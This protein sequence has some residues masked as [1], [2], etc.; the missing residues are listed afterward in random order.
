MSRRHESGKAQEVIHAANRVGLVGC[1]KSKLDEPAPA[2]EL[3]ISP[4]F[5]GR[6]ARVETTCDRWYVL[7]ALHGM[8][9][10]EQVLDPYDRTLVGAPR[11]ERRRWANQVLEQFDA[12]FEDASS[13]MVEVHAGAAYLDHGLVDGLFDR[14]AEVVN[15]VAGLTMGQQLR[16]YRETTGSKVFDARGVLPEPRNS[17]APATGGRYAPLSVHLANSGAHEVTVSFDE[18]EAILGADLPASARKHRAWWAN[19]GHVQADAW[20]RAGFEVDH[21]DLATELVRFRRR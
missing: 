19:G 8:V 14:G 2:R 6:R 4:L 18:V 3:Y 5:R 21:V 7:S 10:P 15:P 11:D 12:L 16:W 9:D 13:L 20:G 1:V 17:R